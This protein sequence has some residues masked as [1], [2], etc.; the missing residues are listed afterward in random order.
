MFDKLKQLAKIK[1]LQKSFQDKEFR[2]EKEGIEVVVDGKFN[3]KEVKLNSDLEK[4]KQEK[5]LKDCINKA[6]QK[7]RQEMTESFSQL[8]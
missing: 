4:V 1:N 6:F 3:I 7:V 5:L 2:V 8:M